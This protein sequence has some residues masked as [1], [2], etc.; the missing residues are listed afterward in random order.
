MCKFARN[1]KFRVDILRN[2]VALITGSAT[3]LG[4]RAAIELAKE[5]IDI[6][7]NYVHSK[8]KA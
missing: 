1:L 8:E 4:K 2:K 5:G 3:G 6:I 7:L